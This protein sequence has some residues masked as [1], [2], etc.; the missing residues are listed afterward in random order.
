M[1]WVRSRPHSLSKQMGGSICRRRGAGQPI[2]L[3]LSLSHSCCLDLF[4][5][6]SLVPPPPLRHTELIRE[7]R[8]FLA[9]PGR[10]EAKG[11]IN[12]IFFPL[13]SFVLRGVPSQR[14]P[15]EC[16]SNGIKKT[17]SVNRQTGN[18]FPVSVIYWFRSANTA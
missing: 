12:S 9:S 4:P 5:F 13:P 15:S 8:S 10:V 11:A 2:P 7:E 1:K 16:Q 14:S 3:I 17:Y 18:K 6:S